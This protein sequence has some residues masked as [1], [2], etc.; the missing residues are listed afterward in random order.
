[1]DPHCFTYKGTKWREPHEKARHAKGRCT[2]S[3]HLKCVCVCVCVCVCARAIIT[4]ITCNFYASYV[5]IC[6]SVLW[7]DEDLRD[8]LSAKKLVTDDMVEVPIGSIQQSDRDRKPYLA[9]II[10]KG[11]FM[12]VFVAQ[13]TY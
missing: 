13:V 10:N 5:Q 12:V 3:L 2:P 4:L 11:I 6:F 7:L 1:M 9:K 8:V